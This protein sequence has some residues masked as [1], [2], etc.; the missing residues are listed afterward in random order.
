[1]AV[2]STGYSSQQPA[3]YQPS[4]QN[5][6]QPT[7]LWGTTGNSDI[8]YDATVHPTSCIVITFQTQPS[9]ASYTV[10]ASQGYFTVT[11]SDSESAGLSYNYRIL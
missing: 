2:G 3:Q 10:V 8:C 11:S 5:V 9:G 7:R 1:M 4:M 6:A